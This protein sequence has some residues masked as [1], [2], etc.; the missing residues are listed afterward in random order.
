MADMREDEFVPII[1]GRP[2]LATVGALFDVRKG[3][4]TF[5]IGGKVLEFKIT[6]RIDPP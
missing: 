4:M 5:D 3:L 6:R 1:L 2:F